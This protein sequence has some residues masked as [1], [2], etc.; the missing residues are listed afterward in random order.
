MN[1]SETIRKVLKTHGIDP[2]PRVSLQKCLGCPWI[3]WHHD[4]HLAETIDLAL[5]AERWISTVDQLT[6]IA[7]EPNSMHGVLIKSMG[8]VNPESGRYD[9]GEVWEQNGDGTWGML[10]TPQNGY[11]SDRA[12]KPEDIVLPAL[13]LWTP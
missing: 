2:Q 6:A 12:V 7:P 11:P 10:V 3:G 9:M 8:I 1:Q 13:L 5:T 4:E